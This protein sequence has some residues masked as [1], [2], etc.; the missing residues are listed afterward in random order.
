MNKLLLE[1]LKEITPE[2]ARVKEVHAFLVRVN[3][4]LKEQGVRAKAV[5]GGSF[6][7]EV[8]LFNDFD[9][10]VFVKFSL[11]YKGK[12]L[13]DVLER[14]LKSF[15]PVRVHGSRDYFH[16]REKGITFEIVPV[17]DIK[18]PEDAEN[19]TDFS[20]LHVAWVNKKG[21]KLKKDILLL[22]K[23]CKVNG[24]YGAESYV[25]GFSGH[26]VDLL[27]I[28]YGSFL[29]VLKAAVK[30]K[31]KVVI[32]VPKKYKGKALH[33]LN[34]SKTQG[35]LV[36]VDP[37]QPERNAAAAVSEEKL[38]WFVSAAK[39]FLKL[40]SKEFF[41]PAEVDWVALRKKGV[42]VRCDVV[43][44]SGKEDVVGAK[45]LKAFEFMREGL[46]EFKVLGSGWG[47]D[48]AERA[49]LWFVVKNKKLPA[50]VEVNGPPVSMLDAVSAF[51]KVHKRVK[52]KGA[53][54][55]AVEPRATT[56]LTSVM[57]MFVS[58]KYIK[59]RVRKISWQ[60]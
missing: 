24:V 22:K 46:V 1:V 39:Q 47:W 30:W 6:A 40:Q 11:E 21:K 28:H 15:R 38:L 45:L 25:R 41:V 18:K 26:V 51:K 9:V 3:A 43:P 37:V 17:L 49:T 33:F 34:K 8:W 13:S 7:K 42:L 53:R 5:F 35:P 58:H 14:V 2:R 27:V 31:P 60:S 23:F 50:V 54:W 10:D 57:D 55:V 52:K 16:V 59:S 44:L 29:N 56:D 32:D 4:A 19:V 20:P 36:I 48:K 12:S